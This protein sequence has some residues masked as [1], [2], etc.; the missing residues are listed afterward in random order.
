MQVQRPGQHRQSLNSPHGINERALVQGSGRTLQDFPLIRFQFVPDSEFED[1]L[2]PLDP[3]GL[4]ALADKIS[5]ALL[6]SNL[7]SRSSSS[8]TTPE[9]WAAAIDVPEDSA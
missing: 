7:P 2:P 4:R 8:A 5:R 3:S 1:A 6:Q 9:T